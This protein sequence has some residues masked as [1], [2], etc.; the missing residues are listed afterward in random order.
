MSG[1]RAWLQN[2]NVHLF[3]SA[4]LQIMAFVPATAPFAPILQTVATT[5]T[6]TGLIL[7]ESGSL[8]QADY[9]KIA[10]AVAAGLRAPVETTAGRT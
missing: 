1:L 10:D 9:A 3:F 7:P 2:P 5:L 6:A 8:H 4:I